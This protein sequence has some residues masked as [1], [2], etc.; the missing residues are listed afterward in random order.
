MAWLTGWRYRKAIA[1]SRS[2]GAVTNYQMQILVGQSI[3]A[4]GEAVD[5]GGLCRGDFA[6][7][8]F[9][10]SDGET[11][12]DFWIESLSGTSP[13]QL[14]TVWVEFNSI[15]TGATTFY[16]YYGKPDATAASSGANTF[17]FFDDFATWDTS[18]WTK[19]QGSDPTAG[20]GILSIP[21]GSP[22]TGIVS[23][24]T[25]PVNRA[26]RSRCQFANLTTYASLGFSD[27]QASPTRALI[28]ANYVTGSVLNLV[29]GNPSVANQSSAS[30]GAV[31]G[32]GAQKIYEVRRNSTTDTVG[33]ADGTT[34]SALNTNV[35]TGNL[36]AF[37]F[38]QGQAMS[39][40]WVLVRQYLATE[41]AWGTWGIQETV[42]GGV[43][44]L[45]GWRY[46]KGVAV[47]HASALADFQVKIL[48]GESDGAAGEQVDC[49]G[50][51]NTDFS[52]LRFTDWDG[53]TLL[54]YWVESITGTTP[55]QLA[56]VWV[57]VTAIN[58][59]VFMYYG[60]ASASSAASGAD[61]FPF[62]D[63][64]DGAD[65]GTIPN[66]TDPDSKWDR[67]GN[68]AVASITNNPANFNYLWRN[69][70][71]SLT[72]DM[73]LESRM[74]RNPATASHTVH[75]WGDTDTQDWCVGMNQ[76][77]QHAYLSNSGWN[78]TGTASADVWY[79][80]GLRIDL[81]ADRVDYFMNRA[82]L[83]A[84][85]QCYVRAATGKTN[86]IEFECY[87]GSGTV[88]ASTDWV[89]IRKYNATDPTLGT[90]E[91]PERAD[92]G[93]LGTW[94]KRIPLVID[95]T[96]ISAALTDFPVMIRLSDRSGI[97]DRDLTAIF[98]EI[99]ESYDKIAITLGDGTTELK[100]EKAYW[101]D[102][103]EHL[104]VLFVKVPKVSPAENTLLFLYFDN[105]QSENTTN[106][107]ATGTA[108]AKAVW[109]A[110]FMGVYHMQDAPNGA[111]S[112]L[113]STANAR[114]GAP[115]STVTRV[116]F[117]YGY[118]WRGA[119]DSNGY[120]TLPITQTVK[121]LATVSVECLAGVGEHVGVGLDSIFYLELNASN[122]TR[123]ALAT[124]STSTPNKFLSY[125]RDSGGTGYGAYAAAAF[126]L[127]RAYHVT[128]SYDDASN[129]EYLYENGIQTGS[130]TNAKAALAGTDP[131]CAPVLL[132]W[133]GTGTTPRYNNNSMSEFR[134]SSVV[135]SA[136]WIA[137]TNATLRDNLI[138]FGA[139]E[140]GTAENPSGWS[141]KITI[142]LD[143][144]K[145]EDN[146]PD[147][148]MPVKLSAASGLSARDV[149]DIF[150]VLEANSLKIA[151][152]L[153]DGYT[154][155]PVEV[156]Y[157]DNANGLASLFVRVPIV[158]GW[159]NG[160]DQKI[161]LWYDAAQADNTAYVGARGSTVGK[162][163]WD[164]WFRA[165]Y[166]LD[167]SPGSSTVYDSTE[168]GAHGSPGNSPDL[169]NGKMAKAYDFEKNESDSVTLPK[170]ELWVDLAGGK[171]ITGY[172]G[173]IIEPMSPG[174]QNWI[175]PGIRSVTRFLSASSQSLQLSDHADWQLGGGTGD[176]TIESWFYITD[177]PASTSV[178]AICG[179]IADASNHWG[180]G[181]WND[182]GTYKMYFWVKSGGTFILNAT[183]ATA[184]TLGQLYHCAITRSGNDFKF[185]VNGI[186]AG[187]TTTASITIPNINGSLTIGMF[188]NGYY[189]NGYL[190]DIR[191]SSV[192]RYSATFT[193]PTRHHLT[194]ANTKLLIDCRPRSVSLKA[195]YNGTLEALVQLESL[196][197]AGNNAGVIY[198]STPTS[199][200][201]RF[202]I[203]INGG[204]TNNP[205]AVLRDSQT[206][207]AF[208]VTGTGALNLS[209]WYAL[210]ATFNAQ[211]DVLRL[212]QD[213]IDAAAPNTTAKG[214]TYTNAPGDNITLGYAP[215][216]YHDG[217]IDEV[218][219]S[220]IDRSQEWV[221][222]SR[223]G[224]FDLMAYFGAPE[225]SAVTY[226][227][228]DAAALKMAALDAAVTFGILA[229]MPD[230]AAMKFAALDALVI[231]VYWA[232][233]FMVSP[234]VSGTRP[235]ASSLALA[236]SSG[237]V[238][239][240]KPLVSASAK[241]PGFSSSV[242]KPKAEA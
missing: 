91:A 139:I 118:G 103:T 58:A 6:D 24:A 113:D 61:T 174:N 126:A 140:H 50:L 7:L 20:S 34:S 230:S 70:G 176:F 74:K 115:G 79:I 77:T 242:I 224:L 120:C 228:P 122:S 8:R 13:N 154:Q 38:A 235:K 239:G 222:A 213:G 215:T 96:K 130:N 9:T 184:L 16:M 123:S 177:N 199:S 157:W 59:K 180:F 149:S 64:F 188:N 88:A 46:R 152:T 90:W 205:S 226:S 164:Q 62:F 28:Y 198:E 232:N 225:S 92:I 151:V 69:I 187:S 84:T 136:A 209:Q 1:L 204:A 233:R 18:K 106:V 175:W 65:N 17:E 223:A 231:F 167:T 42:S 81:S 67:T 203:Y 146:L 40:D 221:K 121:G 168:S 166:H 202:G 218:R 229:A 234:L 23:Q 197:G 135:R 158:F 108:A 63:G 114:H 128:A 137:A 196:Q 45:S 147:F 98:T 181:Y 12:L 47:S 107:G 76:S 125:F 95:R 241:V 80:Y 22:A 35:P 54:Y 102:E 105:D 71:F 66:W 163:V 78:A 238:M 185:W 134:L 93:W 26:F 31:G 14:A 86:R 214:S 124:D 51:C 68:V 211:T 172:N 129:N 145:T 100:V 56:T 53:S 104:G 73:I 48:V 94:G 110:N 179:Q 21:T 138:Y 142:T 165:V 72:S 39:V 83:A 200:Y 89:L 75:L 169:V 99:E 178:Y 143:S 190:S 119:K 112:L 141:K 97:N 30:M 4:T 156:A 87:W 150:T 133:A 132:A 217:L 192:A 3:G 57:K 220:D 41:P 216:Y 32:G 109:D 52:D 25:F 189:L 127:S 27:N 5:C 153:E 195:A 101:D 111:G 227:M 19:Y 117:G 161:I 237:G 207:G 131:P 170:T 11:L 60:N 182:G 44:W 219:I 55:N 37:F 183:G 148:P 160:N 236:P 194:D 171:T 2:S 208:T 85:Q 186:Q 191:I 201:T 210:A 43:S 33:Y 159:F 116:P 15:G 49:G 155:I 29:N 36:S 240:V 206:G 162:S 212:F 82:S 193:P 144:S 10:T 173:P